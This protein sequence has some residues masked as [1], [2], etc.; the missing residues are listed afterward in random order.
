MEKLP[1]GV[2]IMA[3]DICAGIMVNLLLRATQWLFFSGGFDAV[4]KFFGIGA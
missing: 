3:D 1:G 4:F 2:G